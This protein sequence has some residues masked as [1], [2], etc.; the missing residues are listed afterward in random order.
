[1]RTCGP[2]FV[3]ATGWLLTWCVGV[4]EAG[5]ALVTKVRRSKVTINQG[6][7]AG[8][9]VGLDVSILRPAE[10]LVVEA[11]VVTG[12]APSEAVV[13]I[14]DHLVPDRRQGTEVQVAAAAVGCL[15]RPV[16]Q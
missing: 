16:D 14:A 5:D 8:L 12:A 9:T 3:L 1:M 15:Q 13:A 11:L 6:A 7:D 10:C 4:A 2:V